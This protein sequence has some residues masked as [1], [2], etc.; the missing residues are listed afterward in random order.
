MMQTT[1]RVLKSDEVEINGK[2]H[3]DISRT[4]S[5]A[6]SQQQG[7]AGSSANTPV[8]AK[9]IDNNSDY[10]LIELTCSCGKKTLVRCEY[11]AQ[12]AAKPSQPAQAPNPKKP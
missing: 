7:K 10:A 12:P 3:L 2:C 11:G 5:S 4:V 1:N 9:I 8:K 6:Q